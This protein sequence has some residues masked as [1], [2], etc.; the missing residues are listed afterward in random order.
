MFTISLENQADIVDKLLRLY[1]PEGAD[2]IDF[3]YGTGAIWWNVFENPSLNK[4]YQVTACDADPSPKLK[5]PI[6][7]LDLTESDYSHL[8]KHDIGVF[9]PPYLIGRPS[10]DYPS[11]EK[12]MDSGISGTQKVISMGFQGKRSWSSTNLNK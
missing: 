10:F 1:Y 9:D 6:N 8:G 4:R 2:I 12:T 11:N 7:K 5:E 3:T